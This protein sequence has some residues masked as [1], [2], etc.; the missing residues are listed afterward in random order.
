MRLIALVALLISTPAHA[1]TQLIGDP[2]G[3]G[4][5]PAGLFSPNGGPADA[6]GD[7]ILE[8]EEQLPDWNRNGSVAIGSGDDFDFRSS[9]ERNGSNGV[10]WTDYAIVGSGAADG[11]TFRFEFPVPGPQDPSYASDHFINFVF[12][13]YDVY[14]TTIDVDGQV[15]ALT[16]Q[17][18]GRDG[19]VQSAFATVP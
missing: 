6:D 2:D 19:L 1:V 17:G 7:G 5:N 3:F 18:G 16:L 12:G 10:Q 15:I 13:D 14:P 9:Q 8:P 11:A 4:I